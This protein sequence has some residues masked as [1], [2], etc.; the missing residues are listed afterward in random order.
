MAQQLRAFE[1]RRPSNFH[2][3]LRWGELM[4]TVAHIS[5][6]HCLYVKVMPNV[7]LV[8]GGPYL[9]TGWQLEQYR[10]ALEPLLHPDVEVLYVLYLTEDMSRQDILDAHRIFGDRL[11]FKWYPR[12]GTTNSDAGFLDLRSAYPQIEVID[13]LDL[14]LSIHGEVLPN[15]NLKDM[16]PQELAEHY[17]TAEQRFVPQLVDLESDFSL[18]FIVEHLS[19]AEGVDY[20]MGSRNGVAATVTSQH[21]WLTDADLHN[22]HNCCLPRVKGAQHRR[23]LRA[24]VTSGSPKAIF[25]DDTAPHPEIKKIEDGANGV[26]SG[27][28]SPSLVAEVFEAELPDTMWMNRYEQFMS[29]NGPRFHGLPEPDEADTIMLVEEPWDVPA[30]VGDVVPFLAGQT[31]QWRVHDDRYNAA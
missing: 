12:A 3:H 16:T 13:D 27:P 11:Y 22:C 1:I 28:I 18:R 2:V 17:A 30:K 20:I 4:H 26:F 21:L 8:P 25:G 9:V 19:S 24:F 29:L 10:D 31:M 15:K 23:A 7:Q 14:I 5:T 6:K